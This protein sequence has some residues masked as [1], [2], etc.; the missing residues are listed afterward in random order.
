MTRTALA[1]SD[2]PPRC[3]GLPSCHPGPAREATT[4]PSVGPRLGR[5]L[6]SNAPQALLGDGRGVA[7]EELAE[8]APPVRPAVREDERSLGR[9]APRECLVRCVAVDL[10]RAGEAAQHRLGVFRAAAGA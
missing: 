8:L 6:P 2:A 9:V 1:L 3:T 10:R 4:L 5:G 7:V